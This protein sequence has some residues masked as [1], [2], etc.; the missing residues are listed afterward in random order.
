MKVALV[1]PPYPLE[2]APSP[3][4][5]L[6]YV[7]TACETVGAKVKIFDY[8]VRRYTKDKIKQDID[9]FRPEIIGATSVTMNFHIAAEII[10]TAK[11]YNPSIITM[12]GGPHVS[13][14]IENTL[15]S[16]PEIDVILIGEG[17]NT[18]KEFLPVIQDKSQWA[19]VKGIAYIDNGHLVKTG[20]REL[21]QNLDSLEI[22]ARNLLPLSRY[23]ALGFPVSII[24]S[25]GCPNQCIFCLGR[26]MV[27]KKV[28]FRSASSI[29]DEIEHVLS[30]GFQRINIADDF[31]TASKKRVR[32]FC[33]EIIK[34]DINFTW[35]AFARVD[36]VD[37]KHLAIM[38]NAGCD[39]VCF[40]IESGNLE[41]LK[42]VKKGITPDQAIKAVEIC[43]DVGMKVHASFIVG[44][45]GE[46]YETLEDTQQLAN[47]LDVEYGYHFLAPFPGTTLKNEIKNY[48]L[49]I[50]S[51][52]W[53]LYDAKRPIVKTSHL[54][55]EDMSNF[56][57]E[58]FKEQQENWETLKQA[59][60]NGDR[61]ENKN[62]IVE[63]LVKMDFIF[64]LLSEDIIENQAPFIIQNSSNDH[65]IELS[66]Q[67]HNI[68]G[69]D[70]GMNIHLVDQICSQLVKNGYLHYE[71]QGKSIKW[72]WT[73]NNKIKSL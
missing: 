20:Q 60:L 70:M 51:D 4:L 7:A 30:Y 72:F 5:G 18:I 25:R 35:S 29:I 34:R 12:M 39:T 11:Q 43:N 63:G 16:Y 37:K 48:D 73:Y 67:L 28:R 46:S 64:K 6:C 21:I 2:L 57:D 42:Q 32:L 8:I 27:G 53:N 14:D 68:L 41:I 36:S 31:F 10:K 26:K 52:D 17:D 38:K 69:S 19:M 55:P 22:P 15:H 62:N 33:N 9:T 23:Q 58:V 71:K 56:V 45:P 24:T 44:L 40:G 54:E 47:K 59:F 61:S 49:E 1:A 50:I 65:I 13:F 3:P 66:K